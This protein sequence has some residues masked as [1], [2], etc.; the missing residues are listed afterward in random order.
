MLTVFYEEVVFLYSILFVF[1]SGLRYPGAVAVFVA[2]R[3]GPYMF[4]LKVDDKY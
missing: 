3:G 2:G 4:I 1:R